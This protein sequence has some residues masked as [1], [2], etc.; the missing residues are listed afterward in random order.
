MQ[1]EV[2][3]AAPAAAKAAA[4]KAAAAPPGTT[5][6]H[7]PLAL[8]CSLSI[9]IVLLSFLVYKCT[10]LEATILTS[11]ETFPKSPPWAA[12]QDFA[13]LC[14]PEMQKLSNLITLVDDTSKSLIT[15]NLIMSL[16]PSFNLTEKEADLPSKI[17][18]RFSDTI[19]ALKQKVLSLITKDILVRSALGGP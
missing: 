19:D 16:W 13:Q 9:D 5:T 10:A 12:E 6:G 15:V 8:D 18:E 11:T 14:G 7:H 3:V 1:F 4:A 17:Y 2:Q